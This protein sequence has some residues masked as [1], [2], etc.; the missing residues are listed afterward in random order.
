MPRFKILRNNL[1]VM[2]QQQ[3]GIDTVALPGMT[4]WQQTYRRRS[5]QP[6]ERHDTCNG[7]SDGGARMVVIRGGQIHYAEKKRLITNEF[8]GGRAG[9]REMIP[10]LLLCCCTS[11]ER[12]CEP[13]PLASKR[14]FVFWT[15]SKAPLSSWKKIQAVLQ[16]FSSFD[17]CS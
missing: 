1:M 17:D 15:R 6:Y 8:W 9:V 11:N 14:G 16:P 2:L 10:W 4:V 12:R 13:F 5:G 7:P 3:T